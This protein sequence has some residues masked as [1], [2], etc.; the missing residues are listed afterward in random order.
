MVIELCSRR[1]IGWPVGESL[2]AGRTILPGEIAALF[3]AESLAE[4]VYGEIAF[5]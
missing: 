5:A 2:P 1:V 3:D 4:P